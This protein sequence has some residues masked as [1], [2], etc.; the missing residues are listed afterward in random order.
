MDRL[1]SFSLLL[2]LTLSIV[3]SSMADFK[4]NVFNSLPGNADLAVHCKSA[5]SDLGTQTITYNH[6][7]TWTINNVLNCDLSWGTVKGNFDLYDPK[8]DAARCAYAN[9]CFWRAQPDGLYLFIK[10]HKRLE[11]QFKWPGKILA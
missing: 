8:R 2:L 5:G 7:F 10:D 4:A 11:L 9:T 1:A 6:D 3:S